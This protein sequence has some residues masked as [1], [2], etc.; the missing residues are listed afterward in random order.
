MVSKRI[1][2]TVFSYAPHYT[3][4]GK[5]GLTALVQ[6]GG[7]FLTAVLNSMVRYINSQAKLPEDAEPAGQGSERTRRLAFQEL[8]A[9][10][11][12]GR[13]LYRLYNKDRPNHRVKQLTNRL[14][15][16]Q[17]ELATRLAVITEARDQD[18]GAHIHRVGAV[19]AAL[20][21]HL[22]F[23]PKEAQS[24]ELAAQLH[25]IGKVFVPDAILLKKGKLTD[26]EYEVIKTHTTAG[27]Q[28]LEGSTCPILKI[29]RII[30]ESHHERWDGSG[31][32]RGLKGEAIPL[33]ARIVA[34]VD[35]LDALTHE[36]PYK[37]AW[38]LESALTEIQ[39]CSGTQFDPQVVRALMALHRQGLLFERLEIS[40]E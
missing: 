28:L 25:D 26:D 17:K 18:T 16:S 22:G 23:S 5:E 27:A 39:R 4:A 13:Y 34:V 31:Y 21:A 15:I 11:T 20:A 33:V 36:R 2:N 8:R 40:Q 1:R 19:S 7:S 32:P 14:E 9:L 3:Q 6:M 38:P 35:V 10:L 30:A 24:L 37:V 29:G 12:K